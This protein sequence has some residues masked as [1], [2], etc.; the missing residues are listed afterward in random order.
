MAAFHKAMASDHLSDEVYADLVRELKTFVERSSPKFVDKALLEEKLFAQTLAVDMEKGN[1]S[2]IDGDRVDAAMA[3]TP[4]LH[5]LKEAIVALLA[6]TTAHSDKHKVQL[7]EANVDRA[8]L[9]GA[10]EETLGVLGVEK[11][12]PQEMFDMK[13]LAPLIEAL[14]QAQGLTGPEHRFTQDST[15]YDQN[16][17]DEAEGDAE[18][19]TNVYAMED[20]DDVEQQEPQPGDGGD[21][22]G[23]YVAAAPAEVDQGVVDA[24]LNSD[25]SIQ[26][27][28]EILTAAETGL[29]LLVLPC[30]PPS[31][32]TCGCR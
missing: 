31:L 7:Q 9:S 5:E 26:H 2:A 16:E 23:E 10:I 6:L 30:F 1:L 28:E 3:F 21:S 27:K 24:V 32:V 18:M 8:D 19:A 29:L 13:S 25:L 17:G 4:P 12:Q 14:R 15:E 11:Q 22:D 20:D